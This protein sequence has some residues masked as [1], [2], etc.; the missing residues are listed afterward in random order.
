VVSR[1]EAVSSIMTM[2]TS[3]GWLASESG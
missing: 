3:G 2:L 1:E